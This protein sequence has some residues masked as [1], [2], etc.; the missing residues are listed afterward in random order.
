MDG[1]LSP[2]VKTLRD[3]GENGLLRRVLPLLPQRADTVV[4]PGDD[5]AVVRVPGSRIDWLFTTDP[6]IEGRHFEPA[7]PSRQVGHKAVARVVSD[8]AAMGGEP[9]WILADLVAPAATPVTRI[10]GLFAGMA[11]AAKNGTSA[12]SAATPPKATPWNCTSSASAASRAAPPCCAPAPV[13][14]TWY[15]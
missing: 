15:T 12:S 3:I 9:V 14:A 10:R 8:I 1:H 2:T 4:G 11:A 5:C 7:T 6:V 13:P